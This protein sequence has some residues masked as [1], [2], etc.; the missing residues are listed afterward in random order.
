MSIDYLEQAKE[1][2]QRAGERMTRG[3]VQTL[4][5]LLAERKAIKHQEIEEHLFGKLQLDRVTLYRVLEWLSK[6]GFAHKVASDDRVWRFGANDEMH[7][8]QHAHFK[9]TSCTKMLCLNTIGASRDWSLPDGYQLQEVELT[10]KGLCA[11]C[12]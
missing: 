1:A 7:S 2:I 8:H 9:C 11:E 6:K 3:R 12:S 5:V 10:V 4:A